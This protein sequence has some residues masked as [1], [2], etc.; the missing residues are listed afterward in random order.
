MME[1]YKKEMQ[2]AI[3]ELEQAI[4]EALARGDRKEANRL[5]WK[6]EAHQERLRKYIQLKRASAQDVRESRGAYDFSIRLLN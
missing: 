4:E 2:Q 3:R 1:G 5:S 6:L